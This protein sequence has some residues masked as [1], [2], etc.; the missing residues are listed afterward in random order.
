MDD[1]FIY[2]AALPDGFNEAVLPC[3]D[4]YTIYIN[5]KL[6]DNHRL[7]AFLHAISHINNNDWKCGN[8][9]QIEFDAHK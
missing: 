8:V 3:A 9:Q 4:G 2:L 6:D 7:A 1:I 5:E